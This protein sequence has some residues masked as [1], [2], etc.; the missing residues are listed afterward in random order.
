MLDPAG[1]LTNDVRLNFYRAPDASIIRP[2]RSCRR[3]CLATRT[4][5][6]PE[7]ALSVCD[8]LEP[9]S[10]RRCLSSGLGRAG[11]RMSA[12]GGLHDVGLDQVGSRRARLGS[13]RGTFSR[14]RGR[15]GSSHASMIVSSWTATATSPS[16]DI[17]GNPLDQVLLEEHALE[18]GIEP[19]E[20]I[21][22]G[23]PPAKRLR[24]CTRSAWCFATSTG[25]PAED[26]RRAPA[27]RF[28]HCLEYGKAGSNP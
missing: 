8:A 9:E 13:Q 12:E 18:H 21:E 17:E 26:S 7:R 25:E 15:L 5:T 14:A 6:S 4:G 22:I 20:V 24:I 27:D 10:T 16:S 19:R 1:R 3:S 23:S 28:R 11:P 2:F